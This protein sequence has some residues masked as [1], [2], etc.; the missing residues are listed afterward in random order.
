[1][2]L[3]EYEAIDKSLSNVRKAGKVAKV[4]CDLLIV[5]IGIVWIALLA[6]SVLGKFAGSEDNPFSVNLGTLLYF[7]VVL[8]LIA[9]FLKVLSRIFSGVVNGESPFQKKQVERIRL[10]SYI[11]IAKALIEAAFSV[12]NSLIVQIAGWN[13]MCIDSGLMSGRIAYVDAGALCLAA[14]VMCLSIVFEYGALLQR[15]TDDAA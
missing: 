15:L 5:A 6:F 2:L 11:M 3:K 8:C 7:S 9:V 13:F 14:V 1:M 4:I 12:G 10:L